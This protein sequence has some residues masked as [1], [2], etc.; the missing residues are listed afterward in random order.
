MP[1]PTRTVV[2]ITPI[3][4]Q[5]LVLPL[6]GILRI[7]IVMNRSFMGEDLESTSSSGSS[8]SGSDSESD[9]GSQHGATKKDQ[10]EQGEMEKREGGKDENGE[11]EQ[12]VKA[13]SNPPPALLSKR[14]QLQQQLETTALMMKE[15]ETFKWTDVRWM[16]VAN[17]CWMGVGRKEPVK[18]EGGD[19]SASKKK[20]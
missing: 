10:K 8:S 15:Q 5:D 6:E 9:I 18:V 19:K 1:P 14:M 7:T 3:V 16:N 17:T 12:P 11:E 20:K 13:A 2:K 4:I